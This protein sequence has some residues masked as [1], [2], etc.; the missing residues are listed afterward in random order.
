MKIY[1]RLGFFITIVCFAILLSCKE[2]A[3]PQQGNDRA[4][5]TVELEQLMKNNESY[6]LIDVRTDDEIVDGIIPGAI[7]I[8][9]NQPDFDKKI[10]ALDKQSTIVTYC[11]SGGRA[12]LACDQ[13]EAA[14]F[15]KTKNY[16]GYNRWIKERS[17]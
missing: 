1:R 2:Q 10:K 11:R 8:D 16:G 5:T 7:H 9:I 15:S 17:K 3:A 13:L 4:I 6:I 14:G 12:D